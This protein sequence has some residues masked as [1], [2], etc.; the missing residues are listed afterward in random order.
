[1]TGS[2][3]PTRTETT[4][5]A[6]LTERAAAPGA[7]PPPLSALYAMAQQRPVPAGPGRRRST[8]RRV[9]AAAAVAVVVA[10]G[11][12][13][14]VRSVPAPA[15]AGPVAAARPTPSVVDA[16]ALLGRIATVAEQSRLTPPRADQWEYTKRVGPTVQ[17]LTLNEFNGPMRLTGQT[18]VSELWQPQDPTKDPLVHNTGPD[19]VLPDGSRLPPY[20]G[21][22]SQPTL[23]PGGSA[24]PRHL[25]T[26]ADFA[27]LPT[28]DPQA[29]LAQIQRGLKTPQPGFSTPASNA[30]DNVSG[31]V[32]GQLL[33][34]KVAA[35]LYRALA[36]TPGITAADGVTDFVGRPGVAVG[37][38]NLQGE[39]SEIIFDPV[40]L[41][42]IGLR[43]YMATDGRKGKAGQPTGA[44]AFLADGFV[45]RAGQIPTG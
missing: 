3:T 27:A 8:T 35:A 11:V 24:P 18:T 34:P 2:D 5:A 44:T 1:M 23:P 42:P 40:T 43:S 30:I 33:P 9:V 4:V 38:T 12:T 25:S 6:A 20:S 45:D 29:L 21:T 16:R 28:D 41:A 13:V 26:Y 15:G 17:L 19:E 7:T 31:V 39:R 37:A 10:G 32:N 22:V 14:A 36:D